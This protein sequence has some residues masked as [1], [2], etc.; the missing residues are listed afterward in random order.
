MCEVSLG[1]RTGTCSGLSGAW[2][3]GLARGRSRF[4]PSTS[5]R[6]LARIPTL[7]RPI[8]VVSHVQLLLGFTWSFDGVSSYPHHIQKTYTSS[9]PQTTVRCSKL[10]I[11]DALRSTTRFVDTRPH[12]SIEQER[13]ATALG[14]HPHHVSLCKPTLRGEVRAFASPRMYALLTL[15][16]ESHGDETT[17]SASSQSQCA[18]PTA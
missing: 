6:D 1:P 7:W 3:Q 15:V 16:L 11:P 5:R 2:S 8:I 4:A 9:T 12:N 10:A 17:P 18:A 14:L 13:G